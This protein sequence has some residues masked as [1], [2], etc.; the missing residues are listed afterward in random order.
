MFGVGL[1][2]TLALVGPTASGKSALAL[3]IARRR[4]D[5]EL[6]SIDAFQ[7][8]RG[9]DIGTAT[10][11][12]TERAEVP[13]HLIDIVDS[14]EEFTVADFQDRYGSVMAGIADRGAVAILV[15]GTG[16]YL[17]AAIDGLELPGRWPEVRATLESE[18]DVVGPEVLY[19][20][21][22][23]VDPSAAERIDPSNARRIVRALEV[24]LGSGRAFSSFGPG[25]DSYPTVPIV[26]I[27]LRWPRAVLAERID[28][29]VRSMIDAGWLDEVRRL[30][31]TGMSRTAAQAIGYADLAEVVAG[32]RD[33]AVAVDAIGQRTRRFAVR[34]ER[35][36]RRDPRLRWIDVVSDP[37]EESMMIVLDQL[38]AV[39]E[40]DRRPAIGDRNTR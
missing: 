40:G 2:P 3:E 38:E 10:P 23:D 37:V 8:Y 27:G 20:R 18:V 1:P 22:V 14:T 29:R 32:E 21:L 17:R 19:R 33:L 9:M 7:V 31:D 39:V 15:G 26:Q 25:L 5:V 16:L 36:F 13:H 28:R 35:W 12:A 30:V 6:V 24:C 11:S 34:Q 4:G